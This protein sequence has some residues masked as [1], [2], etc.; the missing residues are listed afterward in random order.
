MLGYSISIYFIMSMRKGSTKTIRLQQNKSKHT[1]VITG[2]FF[3]VD[4]ENSVR[5]SI[6]IDYLFLKETSQ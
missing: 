3:H 1:Y 5:D 2:Y 4:S 6:L